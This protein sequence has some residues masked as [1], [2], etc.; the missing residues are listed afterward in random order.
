MVEHELID[1]YGRHKSVLRRPRIPKVWPYRTSGRSF[2]NLRHRCREQSELVG[3]RE[4]VS[5]KDGA[6][7]YYL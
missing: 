6:V 3:F 1:E 4:I 7:Y 5:R 2:E